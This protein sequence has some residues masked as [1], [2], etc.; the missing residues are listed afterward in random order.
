[1]SL[2]IL[3]PFYRNPEKVPIV[4]SHQPNFEMFGLIDKI[5]NAIKTL[6]HVLYKGAVFA[7]PKT[8]KNTYVFMHPVKKYLDLLLYSP[9]L[10]DPLLKNLSQLEKIMSSDTCSVI[11]QVT[12][13]LDLIEVSNVQLF[14]ITERKFYRLSDI[15]WWHWQDITKNVC[16]IQ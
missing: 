12:F 3:K 5:K 16:T 2:G 7:K 15:D 13:D 1:M 10:Q 9:I 6:N 11:K 14:Q 4:I 8:A